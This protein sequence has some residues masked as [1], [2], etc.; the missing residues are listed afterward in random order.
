[1]LLLTAAPGEDYH[2]DVLAQPQWG[3]A[4]RGMQAHAGTRP[5]MCADMVWP[6]SHACSQGVLLTTFR[7]QLQ[8]SVAY[9]LGKVILSSADAPILWAQLMEDR[10]VGDRASHVTLL[11]YTTIKDQAQKAGLHP[12]IAQGVLCMLNEACRQHEQKV[13]GGAAVFIGVLGTT[14]L[15]S[16]CLAA[17]VWRWQWLQEGS[18]VT[19]MLP[20]VFAQVRALILAP[21][22]PRQ[23][24]LVALSS[25]PLLPPAPSNTATGFI[26]LCSQGVGP[27]HVQCTGSD[28]NRGSMRVRPHNH[29]QLPSMQL[30]C[31][32][33]QGHA[34]RQHAASQQTSVVQPTPPSTE[35]FTATNAGQGQ[36]LE[37]ASGP[38]KRGHDDVDAA[39]STSAGSGGHSR[40]LRPRMDDVARPGVAGDMG[41]AGAEG[42]AGLQAEA[43]DDDDEDYGPGQ[44][45]EEEGGSDDEVMDGLQDEAPEDNVAAQAAALVAAWRQRETPTT[46]SGPEPS[47]AIHAEHASPAPSSSPRAAATSGARPAKSHSSSQQGGGAAA[48]PRTSQHAAPTPPA[49]PPTSAQAAASARDTS[50][51]QGSRFRWRHLF[52]FPKTIPKE[53]LSQ[54]LMQVKYGIDNQIA[55]M[56]RSQAY[57]TRLLDQFKRWA[58]NGIQLDRPGKVKVCSHG[59]L[60]Y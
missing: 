13:S 2:N 46:N 5:C 12:D 25:A 60:L 47:F 39:P 14:C 4:D 33:S 30:I 51:G 15:I 40:R 21:H 16:V 48:T 8:R 28:D 31:S 59:M 50:G 54:E 9:Q 41:A 34:A 52:L 44:E 24:A 11:N 53:V 1:M 38:G 7:G 45:G 10:V 18:I 20:V 37:G 32:P 17:R 19:H 49:P 42:G 36:C 58:T 43:W 27:A 57:I 22:V 35:L 3:Q 29:E 26:S 55:D 23:Q 6:T 56:P